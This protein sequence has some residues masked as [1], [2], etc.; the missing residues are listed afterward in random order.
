MMTLLTNIDT[1][2][3]IKNMY[4][5]SVKI[6]QG[7]KRTYY[8]CH[9]WRD[10]KICHNLTK[11]NEGEPKSYRI[12]KILMLVIAEIWYLLG[13]G[14]PAYCME[15]NTS[16]NIKD[17]AE[18]SSAT[19]E[20]VL[21]VMDYD[22]FIKHVEDIEKGILTLRMDQFMSNNDIAILIESFYDNLK[23][24]GMPIELVNKLQ[25]GYDNGLRVK[26]AISLHEDYPHYTRFFLLRLI[27]VRQEMDIKKERFSMLPP[28]KIIIDFNQQSVGFLSNILLLPRVLAMDLKFQLKA[29]MFDIEYNK[30]S[31]NPEYIKGLRQ[32]LDDL[33]KDI[34]RS[35]VSYKKYNQYL[36]LLIYFRLRLNML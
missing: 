14:Q 26:L 28:H 18:V 10:K 19:K 7:S 20:S 23:D 1:N 11:I 24:F 25:E 27:D 12:L 35:P 33:Q 16:S 2:V 30:Q 6:N 8:T 32:Y 34:E 31:V 5:K 4:I 13:T 9:W 29:L 3:K 22:E 15:V 21:K 36:I 17:Q